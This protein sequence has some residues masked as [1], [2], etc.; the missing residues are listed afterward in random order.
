MAEELFL[1]VMSTPE[2]GS[3]SS[4]GIYRQTNGTWGKLSKSG[5]SVISTPCPN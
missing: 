3:G 5:G 1:N 2:F 4:I